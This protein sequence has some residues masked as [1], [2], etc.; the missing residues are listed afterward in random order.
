MNL[1]Y[2]LKKIV[3]MVPPSETIAD[4]GCDHAYVSIELVK[5]GKAKHALAC[6]IN[7]GPLK[8]A[9]D[10]IRSEG[11]SSQIETR[12]SDGLKA[13]K[14]HEADSVIIAGMG[15][16]LM[17]HILTG[18]LHDFDRFILSPQSDIEHFRRFLIENN[19]LITSEA[20]IIDDK[21]FYTILTVVPVTD[22][23]TES[24]A[25]DTSTYYKNNED[26]VYGGLLIRDKDE[27]LYQ[28][29]MKEKDRYENILKK[30]DNDVIRKSHE[31]CLKALEAYTC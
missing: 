29:L 8:S 1:P 27:I 9:E 2:R 3:D 30:T 16:L 15:G 5:T 17:E 26:F 25:D 11:L 14:P 24:I 19:M 12:L 31:S 13:V 21:K 4:V 20:M 7:K 22:S 10:N 18:R 23:L 28:F 6:D